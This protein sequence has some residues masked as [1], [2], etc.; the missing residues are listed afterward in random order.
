MSFGG[1]PDVPL[2]LA[3]ECHAEARKLLASG[4]DP[5]AQRKAP[6][7]QIENFFESV[8]LRWLVTCP[9]FLSQP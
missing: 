4:I 2:S 6:K 5:M 7:A 8:S 9:V 1:Y 3:R